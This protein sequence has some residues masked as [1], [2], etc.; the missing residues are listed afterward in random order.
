VVELAR[1]VYGKGTVRYGDGSNGP[2]EAGWLA[3]ETAKARVALDVQPRWNLAETVT[4]TLAWYQ[5]QHAG[6]D[7]RELCLEEIADYENGEYY[8]AQP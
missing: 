2:H 5:A 3:L 1:Q 4:R 7:A 8:E 6:A